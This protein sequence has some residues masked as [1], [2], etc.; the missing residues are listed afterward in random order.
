[1]RRAANL[2]AGANREKRTMSRSSNAAVPFIVGLVFFVALALGAGPALEW[3]KT[4]FLNREE[5]ANQK[6][7]EQNR[8]KW[9][10]DVFESESISEADHAY[11]TEIWKD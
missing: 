10:A 3:F 8:R 4:Q 7:E 1:M 6:S 2:V 11:C 5:A 9:C